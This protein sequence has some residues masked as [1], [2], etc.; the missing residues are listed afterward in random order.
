MVVYRKTNLGCKNMKI[1][2]F[3]S[4]IE[5]QDIAMKLDRITGNANVYINT[6]DIE[7]F[8]KI[9][10]FEKPDMIIVTADGAYGKD[11]VNIAKEINNKTPLFWFSNDVSYAELADTLSCTCFAKK[12][13]FSKTL[14]VAMQSILAVKSTGNI[15]GRVPYARMVS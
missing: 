8:P 12:P 4:K 1:L 9:I 10:L 2:T 15:A 5:S 7:E 14:Y 11:C 3:G 13:V 6:F